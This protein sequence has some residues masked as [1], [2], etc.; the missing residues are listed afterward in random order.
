[1]Q[2]QFPTLNRV[3]SLCLARGRISG[4]AL[5]PWTADRPVKLL[6]QL[7]PSILYSNNVSTLEIE[8]KIEIE[9]TDDADWARRR[10]WRLMLLM[11]P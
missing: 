6:G 5:I 1:M 4:P 3:G 8:F 11:I 2:L 10:F 7:N 9:N